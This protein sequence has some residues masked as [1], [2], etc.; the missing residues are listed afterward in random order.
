MRKGSIKV[1]YPEPCLTF[2]F[3][4]VRITRQRV[5]NGIR[6]L[7]CNHVSTD[8]SDVE[9]LYC[10]NCGKFHSEMARCSS[11]GE[12]MGY[13]EFRKHRCAVRAA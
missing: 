11:C 10:A 8:L 4:I 1:E 2:E 7:S 3:V 9:D 12:I 5:Q 13:T 6:C